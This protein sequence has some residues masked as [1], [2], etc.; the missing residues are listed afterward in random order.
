MILGEA[1]ACLP[2]QTPPSLLAQLEPHLCFPFLSVPIVLLAVSVEFFPAPLPDFDLHLQ[3]GGQVTPPVLAERG[4][5][6]LPL[7]P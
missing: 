5:F 6:V 2:F 4:H 7:Q 3:P 1:E